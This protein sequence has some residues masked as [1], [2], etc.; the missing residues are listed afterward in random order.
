MAG[1]ASNG[2]TASGRALIQNLPRRAS[3]FVY[4]AIE[5]KLPAIRAAVADSIEKAALTINRKLNRL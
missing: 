2:R 5:D 1:R 3:R 4:P